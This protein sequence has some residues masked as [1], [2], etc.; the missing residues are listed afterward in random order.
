[1]SYNLIAI[2]VLACGFILLKF[3]D[4]LNSK[5][6]VLQT[7]RKKML[8]ESDGWEITS[9]YD[10]GSIHSKVRV[11]DGVTE[12]HLFFENG[13]PMYTKIADEYRKS[14]LV[15]GEP[16]SKK[17]FCMRFGIISQ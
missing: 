3:F 7:N 6:D 17:S 12:K 10:D 14:N 16:I 11:V 4:S 2:L 8:S 1:M 13:N 9:R 15:F 5:D